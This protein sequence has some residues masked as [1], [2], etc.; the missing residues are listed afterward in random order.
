[1]I[2]GL[3]KIWA[4]CAAPP[5]QESHWL[6]RDSLREML[7]GRRDG[8]LVVDGPPKAPWSDFELQGEVAP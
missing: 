8:E 4:S 6:L 7:G 3:V 2:L 1:M 5:W